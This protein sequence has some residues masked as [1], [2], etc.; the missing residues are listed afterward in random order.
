MATSVG[1]RDAGIDMARAYSC[2]SYT[3]HSRLVRL[4]PRIE[5]S[6]LLPTLREKY[7]NLLVQPPIHATV[8]SSRPRST[9]VGMGATSRLL[10][11]DETKTKTVFS[12]G[13]LLIFL[14]QHTHG[15]RSLNDSTVPLPLAYWIKCLLTFSGRRQ[16]GASCD[17]ESQQSRDKGDKPHHFHSS[18][19]RFCSTVCVTA[20]K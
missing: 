16:R 5:V 12:L 18:V 14:T 13:K 15:V 8:G 9:V 4:A 6:L 17:T 2:S 3:L 7:V 1:Q 20:A 10:T 11:D 19:C